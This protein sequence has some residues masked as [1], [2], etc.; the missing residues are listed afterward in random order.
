MS[1]TKSLFSLA[2]AA[3]FAFP[4]VGHADIFVWKNV[5]KDI[6]LSFPDRWGIVSNHQADEIL[7]I[8][9]P[10]MTGSRE[11]A[12]C[13]VR[14]RDDQ[15][16]KMHPVSHGDEIQRLHYGA[17]FWENYSSEFKHYQINHVQ[18]D[19]GLGRGNASFAD[20]TFASYEH[21]KMVRR[22]IAFASLYNHQVHI[23]ECSAEASSYAKWYPQFMGIV[24][25][26]D[27]KSKQPFK[28]GLYRDFYEGQTVI[29]G[30]RAVDAYTF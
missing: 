2:F 23:I 12:K 1:Y 15:R 5:D 4:I 11:D 9:A 14:V 10:E 25:S 21:P 6:S 26:V 3:V 18:N 7:R 13:R 29:E 28:R 27:F 19:A 20:I 17:D 30:R 24:K 8:A 22:G 16:F